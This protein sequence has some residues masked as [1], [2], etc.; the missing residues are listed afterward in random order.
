MMFL[1]VEE[2]IYRQSREA[3]VSWVAASATDEQIVSGPSVLGLRLQNNL[4]L[5]N[6]SSNVMRTRLLSRSRKFINLQ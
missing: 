1:A 4:L 3:A 5:E 6:S 2:T